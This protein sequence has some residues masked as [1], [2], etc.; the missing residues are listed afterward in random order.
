[1]KPISEEQLKRFLC[2][3]A[4]T[5]AEEC[6]CSVC[7]ALLPELVEG[8][9][10]GAPLTAELEQVVHHMK[11]CPECQEEHDALKVATQTGD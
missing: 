8:E 3:V 6:D 4:I 5:R 10:A 7:R 9:L 2:A 11:V 1:M